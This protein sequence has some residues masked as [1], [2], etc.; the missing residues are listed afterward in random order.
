ME[1]NSST[2]VRGIVVLLACLVSIG[3]LPT[4]AGAQ[5]DPGGDGLTTREVATE[6]AT[7]VATE[8]QPA[9]T[10]AAEVIDTKAG[11]STALPGSSTSI[12]IPGGD[13]EGATRSSTV[14]EGSGSSQAAVQE[15]GNDGKRVAFII[16]NPND[17][18]RYQLSFAGA[19]SL[20][21]ADDGSTLVMGPDGDVDAVVAVP[22]AKD[23]NGVDVPTRYEISGTTLTQ[24]VDHKAQAYAY[25][26]TADPWARRW[27]GISVK[28]NR[29]QT[30]NVMFGAAAATAASLG[31]P[32]P[33]AT[34][35]VGAILAMFTGY[36]NWAYNRGA[37]LAVNR[38]WTGQNWV[39]HYYGGS[40]R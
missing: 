11:V 17:P 30:N 36:T 29:R 14:I 7:A 8:G 27:W 23:A 34:K 25:P 19:S 21:T 3:G 37:C 26:I 20:A 22:W 15:V 5:E 2:V 13:V 1:R 10:G 28:L 38:S 6:V 16:N 39:W 35:V 31:I 40:C 24:I 18:T 4:L 32:D 12:V 33:T 9:S